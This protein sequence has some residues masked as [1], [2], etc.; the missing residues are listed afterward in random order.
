MSTRGDILQSLVSIVRTN[1]KSQSGLYKAGVATVLDH[2]INTLA[3]SGTETPM[4]MVIDSGRDRK[5]VV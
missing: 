5:S 2:D 1:L 3:T 4:V